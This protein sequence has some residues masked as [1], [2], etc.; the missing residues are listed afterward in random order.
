MTN[1]PKPTPPKDKP[2]DRE[3]DKGVTLPDG[4]KLPP[5]S[6]ERWRKF[7]DGLPRN[8]RDKKRD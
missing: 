6:N 3:P 5:I 4:I 8:N 1:E 2:A 7:E